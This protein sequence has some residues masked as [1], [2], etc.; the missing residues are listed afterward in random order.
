MDGARDG[1]ARGGALNVRM[2]I[3]YD[4]HPFAAGRPLVLGGVVV[5]SEQGLAGH[6]DADALAHAVADAMLGA[7]ALGD[8]GT[9]FPDD[10]PVWSGARSLDLLA[11]VRAIAGERGYGI[12]NVDATIVTEHPKLASHV[13]AMRRGLATALEVRIEAV[14]VKATRHEGLGA[15]GRG[16]GLAAL[17]IVLLVPTDSVVPS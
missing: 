8:L 9:H 14:S 16:E 2:G 10:D 3:G 1:L 12:G 7:L 6:S 13:P 4:V 15:L 11:R 17:A 5:P